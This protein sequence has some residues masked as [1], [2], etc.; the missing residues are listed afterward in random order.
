MNQDDER[1]KWKEAMDK[2]GLTDE[3]LLEKTEELIKAIE[4][5]EFKPRN[6]EKVLNKLIDEKK[7]LL[8][9]INQEK[10]ANGY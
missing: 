9:R 2:A 7:W 4:T 8:C 6:K 5:G 10:G 3:Y 1:K